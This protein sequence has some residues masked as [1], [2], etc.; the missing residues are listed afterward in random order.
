MTV[1]LILV[2]NE[3][4]LSCFINE[5]AKTISLINNGYFGQPL[6][7]SMFSL[8][9]LQHVSQYSY[10]GRGLFTSNESKL[11]EK[12]VRL[13]ATIVVFLKISQCNSNS[14]LEMW[15]SYS[16]IFDL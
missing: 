15:N 14:D 8:Q 9:E 1:P 2:F 16:D 5:H 6:I 12:L 13:K 10:R 3:I 11:L 4:S 7:Q